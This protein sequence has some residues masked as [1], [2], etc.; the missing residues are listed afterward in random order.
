MMVKRM[1]V[2]ILIP[3]QTKTLVKKIKNDFNT[4]K[5]QNRAFRWHYRDCGGSWAEG[6]G[7]ICFI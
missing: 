4:P 3:V 7:Y 1:D 6:D 5:L 2:K